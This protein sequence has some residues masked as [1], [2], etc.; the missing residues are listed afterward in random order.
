MML[1][2]CH[3]LSES[4]HRY[5]FKSSDLQQL[6]LKSDHL[7]TADSYHENDYDEVCGVVSYILTPHLFCFLTNITDLGPCPCD[8]TSNGCD[9]NCCCD[10]DCSDSDRQAFSYCLPNSYL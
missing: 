6:I 2:L 3:R 9:V 8:L 7:A 10:T 5:C 1:L 4:S